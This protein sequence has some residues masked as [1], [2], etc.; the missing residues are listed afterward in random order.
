MGR[1]QRNVVVAIIDAHLDREAGRRC[2]R[3]NHKHIVA[4][5]GILD[6]VPE[7]DRAG[8]GSTTAGRNAGDAG[9]HAAIGK[10]VVHSGR[11]HRAGDA[12]RSNQDISGIERNIVADDRGAS[13]HAQQN[14]RQA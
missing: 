14:N 3:G 1:P 2:W 11:A 10:V 9:I 13:R 6:G 8:S 4:G 7:D 5:A 12:A